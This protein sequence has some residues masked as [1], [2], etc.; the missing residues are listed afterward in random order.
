MSHDCQ[1]CKNCQIDR[2]DEVQEGDWILGKEK[3]LTYLVI[4]YEVVKFKKIGDQILS[5]EEVLV[6]LVTEC[7]VVKSKKARG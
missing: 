4:G 2:H 3:I 7:D 6:G 5:K 1:V